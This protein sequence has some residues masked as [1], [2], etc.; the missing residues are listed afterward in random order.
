MRLSFCPLCRGFLV[1]IESASTGALER[2]GSCASSSGEHGCFWAMLVKD[3]EGVEIN[4]C[5]FQGT[6]MV[7]AY[8]YV[9]PRAGASQDLPMVLKLPPK[10]VP[11]MASFSIDARQHPGIIRPRRPRHPVWSI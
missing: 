1:G 11:V 2:L 7:V 4:R 10:G 3:G 8:A 5:F 9:S 6:V